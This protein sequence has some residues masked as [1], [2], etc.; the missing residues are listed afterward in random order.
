MSAA[1]EISKMKLIVYKRLDG[2][3]SVLAPVKN[4]SP[5]AEDISDEDSL[6][7]A[8]KDVPADA[9]DPI[10]VEQ[11]DIPKDR[12]FREAWIIS[13]NAVVHDMA[14]ARE[15]HKNLIRE[16]RAPK[17]AALDIAYMRADE[18]GDEEGKKHIAARKQILRDATKLPGIA[19]AQSVDEL[20]AVWL[21]EL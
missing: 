2:G 4:T 14:K 7:R 18:A 16:F 17:L 6:A 3:I 13:G 5:V 21:V 15:I 11:A 12:A 10:E 8:W 9:I 20:R 19:A 1:L